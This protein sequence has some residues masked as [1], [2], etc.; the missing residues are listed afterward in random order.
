M[1]A[2]S[3]DAFGPDV[4]EQW[5][6]EFAARLL[7][8]DVDSLDGTTS[9][10]L[11][12][13]AR[14]LTGVDVGAC[15]DD[16]LLELV[17]SMEAADRT[18]AAV[19]GH[20]LAELERRGTTEQTVGLVTRSWLASEFGLPKS[21]CSRRVRVALRLRRTLPLVDQALAD[22]RLGFDHARLLYEL[23]TPRVVDAVVELQQPLIDLAADVRFE[24]WARDVRD[25]IAV[26]DADGGHQPEPERSH[27]SL[28]HGLHG[29]LVIRGV[30]HGDAARTVEHALRSAADRMFHRARRDLSAT[31]NLPLPAR[32]ELLAA[33]LV[34]L[35]RSGNAAEGPR[36]AP[37]AD[38]TLVV[39]ADQF[40]SAVAADGEKLD[41][42]T[43]SVLMCDP[44]LHAL[45]V[46]SLGVPLDL[47]RS[48]R[49]A[50]KDQ[51]RAAS[52]RDGGCVFPGCDAPSSWCDLHHVEHAE[53]GGRTDL[54][55][56][57]SLCRHH[58][59][60]S[61]RQG[62]QMRH[63]PDQWFSWVTPGGQTLHSQRHGRRKC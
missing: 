63:E 44:V 22:G 35:L 33:A 60:I 51:R 11:L 16:E 19:R 48:V 31:P 45:V 18:I 52:V 43:A 12:Q 9:D 17:R 29:E 21:E 55:N 5:R 50:T 26:L 42:P 27:L 28:N 34:D 14:Q 53:H 8:S 32:N 47:G 23:C 46:D 59:G 4:L 7:A 10:R 1:F 49:F 15:S 37:A 61:H 54:R 62:W 41:Q 38:V 20:V 13:E 3:T 56:L 24:V 2:P 30:L 58:H 57:A 36:H 39:H 25:L 40:G 6:A